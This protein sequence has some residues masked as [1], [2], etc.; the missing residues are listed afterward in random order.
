MVFVLSELPSVQAMS[1]KVRNSS[2]NAQ[3]VSVCVGVPQNMTT[4]EATAAETK[5]FIRPLMVYG[6]L[7]VRNSC[8]PV[9]ADSLPLKVN[10]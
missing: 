4:F 7:L 1:Y 5:R 8:E 9:I 6:N 3:P 2:E 10:R